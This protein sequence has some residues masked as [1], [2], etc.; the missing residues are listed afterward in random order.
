A[1]AGAAST[2]ITD[3]VAAALSY[4]WIVGL[5]FLLIEPDN[6]KRFVRLH[7]FQSLFYAAASFVLWIALHIVGLIAGAVTSGIAWLLLGPLALLIWLCFVVFWIVMVVKAYNNQ[8]YKAPFIGNFA[9]KQVEGM[10]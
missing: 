10:Q 8:E 3:N 5:I 7:S 4:I 9:A 6:K 2:G 1:P